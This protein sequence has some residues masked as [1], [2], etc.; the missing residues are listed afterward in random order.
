MKPIAIYFHCLFELGNPPE[1]LPQAVNIVHEQMVQLRA[2]G[3]LDTASKFVVGI[4][5]GEASREI[6]NL[7]IPPKAEIM[8]HGLDC[9]NENLTICAMHEFALSHP[10]W[11]VL[12][13]HA[14]GASREE[15]TEHGINWRNCMMRHVIKEWWRCI[16]DLE[17]GYESVGCHWMTNQADG[18]QSIWAGNFHFSQSNFLRTLP[19]MTRRDRIKKSGIKSIESRY[20][21]ECFIGFGPRLPKIKDYHHGWK[22]TSIEH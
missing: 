6:A 17:A 15:Q 20:E 9:R 12:Y 21:A 22:P 7:V 18:T 16:E 5:G 13:F 14:K 2:S 1:V 19:S 4:N 8:M 10:G 11:N 3:L